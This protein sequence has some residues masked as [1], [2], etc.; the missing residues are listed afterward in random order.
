MDPEVEM[1]SSNTKRKGNWIT[2][3][4]VLGTM[5]CLTL[6]SG[7]WMA[8]LIVYLIEEF[9]VESIDAAQVFNR[10]NAG[11]NFFPLI[12]AIIAD[13]YLGSF[14]VVAISCCVSFVAALLITLTSVLDS[15][16]PTP[17]PTGASNCESPS[18][19][20]YAVLY[21]DLV[22]GCI[23]FG[24][25]RFTLSTMGANQFD[26]EKD[27]ATFFNWFFFELYF[28][29]VIAF[30]GIVYI[31]DNVSWA[32][33]YEICLGATFIGL[34]VFL[35]GNRF[36]RHD[37]P[38]GSPFTSLA[39]VVVA[40][41]RK[42]NMP[43]K[44]QDLY[45]QSH[46][47]QL[48][49][50]LRFLNKAA[51]ETEGDKKP[52]GSIAKPWRLCTVQQ[53]EDFKAFIKVFPIWSSSIL[54]AVEVALVQGSCTVLQAL[55]M[56]RQLG[57]LKIPAGT[58]TVL[59]LISSS[60]SLTVIDRYFPL[61]WRKVMRKLPTPLHKL[62]IGHV[63]TALAMAVAAVVERR[64]L[65]MNND[66]HVMSAVW[67][68]PQLI[69]LGIGEAFYFP[70]QVALYYQE[71]PASLHST[72]TAISSLIVGIAFYLSTAVIDIV[73]ANSDWLPDDIDHGRLDN[74]YWVLV[75]IGIVNFGYF[76]CC[77]K[78]FKYKHTDEKVVAETSSGSAN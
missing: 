48:T 4:F 32:L 3:P 54:V 55:V 18:K 60:A 13:S 50:T 21:G 5:A 56:D 23:G 31:Q 34:A 35:V 16:R 27:Q 19:F 73:R 62:G 7:G 9:N 1:Q 29:S 52:D 8:N 66:K 78:F 63:I 69:I 42:I 14:S 49:N 45:Y 30:T 2:F 53:V 74:V 43:T 47:A 67:L 11:I 68:F 33:G 70:G 22:L 28:F 65:G 64:R 72:A 59:A 36:Y 40:S 24:I 26:K 17:C 6:A 51:I 58:I 20:Q 41:I 37:K 77:A 71:F 46:D 15:L 57:H 75:V 61:L 10:V 39:Q 25:S 12:G 44:V 38:K 76:L